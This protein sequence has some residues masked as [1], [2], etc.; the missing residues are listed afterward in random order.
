MQKLELAQ[1]VRL[2][3]LISAT[4]S[5]L[6]VSGESTTTSKRLPT[7]LDSTSI[8]SLQS[9]GI[10]RESIFTEGFAAAPG[11]VIDQNQLKIG[12]EDLEEAVKLLGLNGMH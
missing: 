10:S 4:D 3:A 1:K 12:Q 7:L 6:C 8:T 11:Q 2:C 9:T 5:G